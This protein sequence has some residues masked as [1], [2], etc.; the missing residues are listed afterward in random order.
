MADWDVSFSDIGSDIRRF[1]I[2]QTVVF[3]CAQ[4]PL[5]EEQREFLISLHDNTTTISPTGWY[6]DSNIAMR[7]KYKDRQPMHS[8]TVTHSDTN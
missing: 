1:L 6:G 3:C 5:T 7:V 2:G 4:K 8:R